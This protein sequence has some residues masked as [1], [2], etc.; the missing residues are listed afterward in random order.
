MKR[1][2]QECLHFY[3]L[4]SVNFHTK[5][6]LAVSFIIS[7]VD[8]NNAIG[9]LYFSFCAGA[10]DELV[11]FFFYGRYI[12]VIEL[13]LSC[14]VNDFEFQLYK[15]CAELPNFIVF[16]VSIYNARNILGGVVSSDSK[17][18]VTHKNLLFGDKFITSTIPL[19]PKTVG[20]CTSLFN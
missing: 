11:A 18:I 6:P 8:V 17:I 12:S 19:N 16:A 1:N 15:V 2:R 4:R 3:C 10:Q 14:N 5:P 20:A 7:A 9:F 13:S